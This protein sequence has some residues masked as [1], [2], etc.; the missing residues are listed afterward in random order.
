MYSSGSVKAKPTAE[1]A[2]PQHK[3]GDKAGG[4]HPG[5]VLKVLRAQLPG[6]IVARAVAAEKAEGL[7]NGHQR[8][9]DAH[10]GG[11]AGVDFA[12]EE[13]VGHIIEGCHQHTDDGR[14]RQLTDQLRDGGLGHSIKFLFSLFFCSQVVFLLDKRKYFLSLYRK[15]SAFARRCAKSLCEEGWRPPLRSPIFSTEGG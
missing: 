11:G 13:G 10:R 6:D 8:E 7:D 4:G 12:D 15:G 3:G 14:H 5:G 1:D 2:Q 9:D